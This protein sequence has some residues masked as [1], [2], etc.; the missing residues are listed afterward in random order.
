M[1]D[2]GFLDTHSIGNGNEENWLKIVQKGFSMPASDPIADIVARIHMLR[3]V[4]GQD[5]PARNQLAE[6]MRAAIKEQI[7]AIGMPEAVFQRADR[8]TKFCDRVSFDFCFEKPA[9]GEISIYP[10]NNSDEEVIVKYDVDGENIHITP[11]PLELGDIRGYLVGYQLEGYP[12]RLEPVL[13]PYAI[14]RGD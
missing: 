2:R 11:W 9:K 1:H 5:T 10:K 3:L 8:I 13:R 14:R 7:A 6:E 4:T 12:E